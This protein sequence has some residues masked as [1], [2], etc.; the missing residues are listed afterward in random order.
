MVA[1][2]FDALTAHRRHGWLVRGCPV[3]TEAWMAWSMAA[4]SASVPWAYTADTDFGTDHVM[5]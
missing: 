2:L 3:V 1:M 4:R 5:S